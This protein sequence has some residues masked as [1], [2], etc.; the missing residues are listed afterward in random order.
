MIFFSKRTLLQLL[1][2]EY[3]ACPI[4]GEEWTICS[5][6]VQLYIPIYS[7]KKLN[8]DLN[9]LQVAVNGV[10]EMVLLQ[11]QYVIRNSKFLL[12]KFM[13]KGMENS[14]GVKPKILCRLP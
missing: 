12:W 13:L 5:T 3:V 6:K 1:V 10:M 7:F 11:W 4:V 14:C 9:H 2:D 8:N